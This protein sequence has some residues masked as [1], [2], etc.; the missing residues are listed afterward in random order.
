M[1][2]NKFFGVV[3]SGIHNFYQVRDTLKFPDEDPEVT[4]DDDAKEEETETE[5][6][7]EEIE[8]EEEDNKEE[9]EPA[10]SRFT[11]D[12][13]KTA[14]KDKPELLKE[15]KHA[16]FREQ[17]F[18]EYFPTIEDAKRASEAQLAYEE[19]TTA[20]VDG[21]AEKF[22]TELGSESG[23]GLKKFAENFLPALQ[24]KDKDLFLDI[25]TPIVKQFVRNAY[26][27]GVREKNDNVANA[28]KIIHRVLFGGEYS[29]VASD[30]PL[31]SRDR[32]DKKDDKVDK[33]KEQYFNQKYQGLRNEVATLC[34]SKLEE[35]I[36][37]GLDDLTKTKPGLKKLITK[38]VKDRILEEMDKD[39]AYDGR[40]K[41]LWKREE[42]NGF[43]GTLKTS[44]LTNFMG[45][46]RTL[47][48]KL[49][50]QARKEALGKEDTKE[51]DIKR[52]GGGREH[53]GGSGKMSPAI[54]KEKGLTTRQ[55]FD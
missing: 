15:A 37:K 53:K 7:E 55:I 27:Y 31:L 14:F 32:K 39:A 43:S 47:I 51:D 54:A 30:S 24:E 9:D 18:T 25:S 38:D 19:I 44:F 6:E 26:A 22:I 35:E 13:L 8:T 49:R 10:L 29:D 23:D 40:M 2:N 45:K 46:A 11:L 33:D 36:G 42:R 52:I 16:F 1:F 12:D 4:I 3:N 48:P 5:T 50:A 34:Y 21:D 20:V 17:Q 41:S 28:A